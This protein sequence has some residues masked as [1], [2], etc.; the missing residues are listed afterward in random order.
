MKLPAAFQS[1]SQREKTLLAVLG[2]TVLV[3]GLIYVISLL[4]A[5]KTQS[6]PVGMTPPARTEEAILAEIPV[7]SNV[8][9]ATIK[10]PFLVPVQYRVRKETAPAG[11]TPGGQASRPTDYCPVLNGIVSS[12][13]TK[14]AI[15]EWGGSSDTVGVGGRIGQYTVAAITDAQVVLNGPEGRQV[16]NMEGDKH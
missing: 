8:Q 11:N 4:A 9:A 12:G 2:F 3:A 13:S 7:K 14:M 1:C 10:N 6:P 5:A 16:L 15:I